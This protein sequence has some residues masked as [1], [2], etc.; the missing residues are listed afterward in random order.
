M[1]GQQPPPYPGPYG[2]Q[3]GQQPPY[4]GSPAQPP[5]YTGPYGQPGQ[6]PPYPGQQPPPPGQQPPYPGQQPPYPGQPPYAG[7]QQYPGYPQYPGYGPPPPKPPPDSV[8][9]MI[10]WILAGTAI[11]VAV[12]AF[13]TWGTV[14]VLDSSYD[15]NGVTGSDIPGDD[16]P[17]DGIITLIFA[18][19]VLG[20]ALV[21]ALGALSLTAGIIGTVLGALIT[22]VAIIDIADFQDTKDEVR[23]LSG[24]AV[25]VSIGIGLWLTL[26]AGAVMLVVGVV[27]IVKR[28]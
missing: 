17:N 26:A 24:G 7:Q 2:E 13:L 12:A 10:G 25:D 23:A 11:V 20:F 22:L 1:S 3:P 21:R 9:R 5:P 4:P 15:V 6:Q 18:L 27:G 19:A 28:R 14:G 16:E 8:A